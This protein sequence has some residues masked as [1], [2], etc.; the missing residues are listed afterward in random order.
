MAVYF[1]I[2]GIVQIIYVIINIILFKKNSFDIYLILFIVF[3]VGFILYP[4]YKEKLNKILKAILN[5]IYIVISII[6][7][8]LFIFI[9]LIIF[10]NLPKVGNYVSKFQINANLEQEEQA[11]LKYFNILD[12][13]SIGIDFER[14]KFLD[15]IS[16]NI[17]SQPLNKYKEE[18]YGPDFDNSI[19]NYFNLKNIYKA[20][21]ADISSLLYEGNIVL[22]Q[23]KYIRLWKIA[24]N[25]FSGQNTLI[26]EMV[27]IV[28][29]N[30]LINYYNTKSNLLGLKNNNTFSIYI[31]DIINKIDNSFKKSL[32]LE[33]SSMRMYLEKLSKD[34]DIIYSYFSNYEDV[35]YKKIFLFY[36][37]NVYRSKL[38]YWP[39]FDK[40]KTLK[41]TDEYYELALNL[42]DKNYID[43]IND[44]T[45]DK[46]YN[47]HF[48][49][50]K[51]INPTGKIFY[52]MPNV[53]S[54]SLR[55][56]EVKSRL[57][58]LS[59]LINLENNE[60]IEDIPFND[61]MENDFI[62][63][64]EN[65]FLRIIGEKFDF[66]YLNIDSIF[67]LEDF[68]G[69]ND[70]KKWKENYVLHFYPI[71]LDYLIKG[72]D[73][74]EL[75]AVNMLGVCLM[76][77]FANYNIEQDKDKAIELFTFAAQR[78][79]P[80]A[81]YNLAN[82]YLE[83]KGFEKDVEKAGLLYLMAA[84]QGH[85]QSQLILIELY[86]NP[87]FDQNRFES[88]F[89]NKIFKINEIE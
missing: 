27:S 6:T 50:L 47:N 18:N 26:H 58:V 80:E 3:A 12:I 55:I 45:L 46:L 62:F 88:E 66:L 5:G 40:N 81:Q 30:N 31:N 48:S 17:I 14:D 49:S 7:N 84:N 21:L 29:V 73:K 83:G 13:D 38:Y 20:E 10:V 67:V 53:V 72:T 86:Q 37:F 24:N 59:Y 34:Q 77:S 25:L 65:M 52:Y 75:D 32:L 8:F 41:V 61:L 44:S 11:Y 35:S 64:Y 57:M 51:L 70:F 85:K 9:L 87:Y 36:V 82:C 1:L 15:F 78:G 68:E 71:A 39:F 74:G 42:L 60:K 16:N 79:F 89:W 19:P 63:D 76:D 28:L 69:S 4:K 23:S 2:S 33:Y 22:A 56:K 54:L 43:C